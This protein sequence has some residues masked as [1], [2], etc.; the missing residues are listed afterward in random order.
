V[1]HPDGGQGT[2]EIGAFGGGRDREA[3]AEAAAPRVDP[4][5]ASGLGVDEI[6]KPDVRQ[7]L[8]AGIAHL[9]S[10][11]VVMPREFEE[12]APPLAITSKVGH[13]DDQRTLTRERPRTAKRARE[14]R[15][16]RAFRR[17]LSAKRGGLR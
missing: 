2:L 5:L 3:L 16:T 10:Y 9:D 1:A 11:D 6:E 8:L 13:D 4:Q 12:R 7:L 17:R 15:R 14:C